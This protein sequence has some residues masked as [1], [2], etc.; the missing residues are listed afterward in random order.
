MEQAAAARQAALFYG[1]WLFIIVVSVID[2]LLVWQ[3]QHQI[4]TTELNPVGRALLMA[5]GGR[6]WYLLGVKFIGTVVACG[7]LLLL[8]Q[9]SRRMGL[10]VAGAVAGLQ[11][12][13]LLFLFL[14]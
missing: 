7:V 9:R 1:L 8:W 14:A 13:L 11:L 6:V 3:H 5:N 2:G 4:L 10:I 12:C